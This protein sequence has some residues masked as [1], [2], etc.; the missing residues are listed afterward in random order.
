MK[1][2]YVNP[3]MKII[4]TDNNQSK[5]M[6]GKRQVTSFNNLIFFQKI[7]DKVREINPG[8]LLLCFVFIILVVY[9]L[10]FKKT[11]QVKEAF[12]LNLTDLNDHSKYKKDIRLLIRDQSF[13]SLA[14]M[15]TLGTSALNDQYLHTF[16]VNNS[17]VILQ[18]GTELGFYYRNMDGKL[19]AI[20]IKGSNKSYSILFL[21]PEIRLERVKENYIIKNEVVSAIIRNSDKYLIS[22]NRLFNTL[23]ENDI[24]IKVIPFLENALGWTID[25]H[26]LQVGDKLKILFKGAYLDD[27][28]QYV[29]DVMAIHL[30]HAEREYFAFRV[31]EIDSS[32]YF[33]ASGRPMRKKFLM[34]PLKYAYITSPYNPKRI[35]PILKKVQPHLGTDY[36]AD[37]GT[38]VYAVGDGIV[39]KAGAETNNGNNIKIKH[40]QRFETQ[41][42]HLQSFS[43]AIKAGR[44]VKQGQIIG[45]VGQTGLATGPHLCY[46]FYLDGRQINHL[47]LIEAINMEN[48]IPQDKLKIFL[49]KRNEY[50][51]FLRQKGFE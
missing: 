15:R 50:I 35:H 45:Y 46:R 44:R 34:S 18:K 10:F 23:E 32:L 7:L 28:L 11:D 27:R 47:R 39:V 2:Q 36:A 17:L 41:Y 51:Y 13:M 26:Y 49:P 33:D 38:P 37:E 5:G 21:E 30:Y 9:I 40:F 43:P 1:I 6:S 16:L 8:Y 25:L 42:L 14:E 12:K 31:E 22:G 24:S 48:P 29:L 20:S 4:G 19:T 3:P